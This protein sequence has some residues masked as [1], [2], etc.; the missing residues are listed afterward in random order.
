MVYEWKYNMPVKAQI[1]GE[2]FE[3]LERQ[4]GYITPKT[5]L[6][7]ARSEMSV[8]HTCF[9]WKDDI[10]AEKYREEQARS[11]IRNLTIRMIESDEKQVEPVRAFV[12]IQQA[13]TSEFI[14]LQNVLKDEELTRQLLEQAKRDLASFTRKYSTLQELRSVF[15]AIAD[16]NGG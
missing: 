9:E 16:F 15:D 7:S 2:H 11:L 1:V 3:Q 6:D 8:I 12:N 5:V 14:S 10:A 4:Q 13:D